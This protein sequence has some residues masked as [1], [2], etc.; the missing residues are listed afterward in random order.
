MDSD[1]R[2]FELRLG[3]ADFPLIQKGDLLWSK[4]TFGEFISIR[5]NVAGLDA[6]LLYP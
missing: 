2:L 5:C 6:M 3:L 4:M 1:R